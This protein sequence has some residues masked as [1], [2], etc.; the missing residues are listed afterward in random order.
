MW[1]E[2]A[3][4]AEQ[5]LKEFGVKYEKIE[6]EATFY[7]PELMSRQKCFRQRRHHRHCSSGFLFRQKI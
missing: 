6:G 7:G 4:M 5:A 2:S 3:E 1:E